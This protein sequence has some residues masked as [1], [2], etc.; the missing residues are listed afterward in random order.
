[1]QLQKK[2]S[3]RKRAAFISILLTG[4]ISPAFSQGMQVDMNQAADGTTVNTCTGA[5]Y[6]SGGTSGSGYSNN[7]HITLTICPDNAVDAINL[8][9]LAFN[10]NPA[11]GAP[12]NSVD[13]F[14]IYD[15]N[16]VTAPTLGTYTGTQLQGVL[17]S[18][19]SFNT[20]GCLTLVFTS[21]STGTGNFS[22]V[23]SC[24]T[25]CQR[26]VAQLA[27]PTDTTVKICPGDTVSFDG[28]PSYAAPGFSIAKYTWD[29]DDGTID[30]TSGATV[31]H[32]FDQPGEYL[33][34]L[35]LLDDND[36]ASTNRVTVQV[37]AG[38]E[39]SFA[40]TSGDTTICLGESVCLVGQA[41]GVTWT[42]LPG[43]N[44]G[45]ATHIPDIVGACFQTTIDF[46]GVFGV[47]Q[48][49]T[50]I[51]DLLGICVNMEH[52]FMGDL[53]ASIRCPNGQSVIMHQQGG[54]GA[55]LGEPID[56][57]ANDPPGV[58]YDYC[59]SPSAT[60]GTWV[61]NSG[62][63][64][65]VN[66][67]LPPGSY[68]SLNSLSGLVGCPLNGVWTLE[69]CDLWASDDGWVFNWWIDFNPA[70]YPDITQFTPVFGPGCD[71]TYWQAN[72]AASAAAIV[73]TDNGCDQICVQPTAPG[74]YSY[75]YYALDDFGCM[76]DTTVTVTVP[77]PVFPDAG[78]DIA[79]CGG[80]PVQV[81]ASIPGAAQPCT[82]T[83][84]LMDSYGD[85]WNGASLSVTV[86]STTT[87]H[88]MS[89]GPYTTTFTITVPPGGTLSV[90]YSSGNWENENSYRITDCNGTV[91]YSAGPYPPTG[92]V[93]STTNGVNWQYSWSP[94]DG[95]S[96]P[97]VLN[98]ILST[99]V[100]ATY[101]LTVFPVGH[102]LCATTDSLEVTVVPGTY[103]GRDSV[104]AVCYNDPQFDMTTFLG[105]PD[106]GG[107][108]Y[109][110]TGNV[111]DSI[112]DPAVYTSGGM[113]RYVIP[114][115]GPCPPD[116]ATLNVTIYQPGDPNCCVVDFTETHTDISCFSACDGQIS[117]V[118]ADAIDYS[119]DGGL[120]FG[121]SPVA[122]GLC[123]GTYR[124][125]VRGPGGC[126]SPGLVT[127]TE[128]DT[129]IA[130]ISAITLVSCNGYT[131]ASLTAT[132]TGGTGPY[133]YSWNDN[134]NQ[135]TPT[136]A[137]N[138]IG[139]GT[140]CVTLTD[141]NGCMAQACA[142]VTEPQ[143]LTLA[144]QTQDEECYGYCNGSAV[145]SVSGGTQPYNYGW[146]TIGTA[147]PPNASTISNL[148]AGIYN[149][150]VS[151]ANGCTIDTLG[152]EIQRP[153]QVIINAVT[154][155]DETCF[156]YCNGS[157]SINAQNAT[158]FSIGGAAGSDAH[159]TGLCA[160]TY[161]VAAI[162]DKGCSV[163]TYATVG[164]PPAV[165]ADFSFR[166]QPVTLF[167]TEVFFT[168]HSI[169]GS[170]YLWDFAGIATSTLVNPTF[171]FPSDTS[172]I[173]PVCLYVTASNGCTD[174][175]C[176]DVVISEEFLV[177]AP[178]A[179]TPDGDGRNDL[180][181]LYG[182]D[183]DPLHF[184]LAV[185]NRWGEQVFLTT[186]PQE[187][188][189]G[190]FSGQKAEPGVYVWRAKLRSEVTYKKIV[191]SGHVTLIR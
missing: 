52:S 172:G 173:Y 89:S 105:N 175:I 158:Q 47:G 92:L 98:P 126:M 177:Y 73:S 121:P 160:A 81:N 5:L 72:D 8:S 94:P 170:T 118:S 159:F 185:F 4:G 125:M 171:V 150:N 30:S 138:C 146:N 66:G 49:L 56:V 67:S 22:A 28:S 55:H 100:P 168:N 189:D 23:I 34:D 188:W 17:I 133:T 6:D 15:G 86:N 134:C 91:V 24:I 108:W 75:T 129:L 128:P 70:L 165:I 155:V 111:I 65:L 95:L 90:S 1:M 13:N 42:G 169:Q 145:A 37:L 79:L 99:P 82:Y 140:W 41:Q 38:T 131:D 107:T 16:S 149:L 84:T 57:T 190:T 29:F 7:E 157:L 120:T 45:G 10:L 80:T 58:G 60:N 184:E 182:N 51:T 11:P 87:T 20:S 78:P 88:T 2:Q 18:C 102:P 83:F 106:S 191:R 61:A 137:G 27:I 33:V 50:N 26:P 76:Y 183:I 114:A 113:F 43:N 85:S 93:Y 96:N 139:A 142:T 31:A 109:D 124:L 97:N 148:C 166:P 179:F 48:S 147:Y 167:N 25:P 104:H 136:A 187:G 21:N 103:A 64:N 115:Q 135:T 77:Q 186:N 144:L 112:F 101:Y 164:G 14:T 130:A 35:Y 69:F 180:F 74:T 163:T 36:C 127:L 53:V 32:A 132:A 154:V 63:A 156:G 71:S 178:N 123:A 181:R 3:W 9:F 162:D 46:Q 161:E 44:L 122:T 176:Y 116:T 141:A 62:Q 117:I 119:F 151:D 39:P 152:F 40:G 12:N 59:W 54:G 110:P 174:S 153:P 19:S 143:P 68:E